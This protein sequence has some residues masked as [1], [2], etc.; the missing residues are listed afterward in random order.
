MM[1]VNYAVSFLKAIL[2]RLGKVFSFDAMS[3]GL[4]TLYETNAR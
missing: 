1:G 4:Y 2:L 3:D